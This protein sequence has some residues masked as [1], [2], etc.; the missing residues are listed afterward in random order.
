MPTPKTDKSFIISSKARVSSAIRWLCIAIFSTNFLG[1]AML[2]VNIERVVS[3]RAAF[4]FCRRGSAVNQSQ[5][6]KYNRMSSYMQII[7]IGY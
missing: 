4:H 5:H 6:E 3:R 1:C 2:D 7:R